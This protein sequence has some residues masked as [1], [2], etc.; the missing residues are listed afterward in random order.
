MATAR[1][2]RRRA[3]LAIVVPA[4]MIG[5][6]TLVGVVAPR[7]AP[8]GLRARV[9]AAQEEDVLLRTP[10]GPYRGRVLDAQ[11]GRPVPDAVVVILWQE[12]E[13]QTT[14]TRRLVTAQETFTDSQGEFTHD[15]R[16]VEGKLPTRT[17]A[18]RLLMFKPGYSPVPDRPQL[19]PPGVPAAPFTVAGATATMTAVSDLD[20][21]SEAFNTFVGMLSAAHLFPGT[22]LPDTAE[23][24]RFELQSLGVRPLP[25]DTPR[26]GR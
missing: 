26:G 22:I 11:T 19:R 17:L 8:E 15:V 24:I 25:S 23:L 20:D 4:V 18:P 5:L 16:A 21:R 9:A 14:G 13:D 3:W 12:I 2:L 1:V 10:A 7:R 6:A